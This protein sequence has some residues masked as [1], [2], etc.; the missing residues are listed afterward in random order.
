MGPTVYAL[1]SLRPFGCFKEKTIPVPLFPCFPPLLSC[2]LGNVLFGNPNK[3]LKQIL[4]HS[5]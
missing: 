4:K 2:A 1:D 5:F 3:L